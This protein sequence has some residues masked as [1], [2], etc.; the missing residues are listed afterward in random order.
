[1]QL[2]YAT[3]QRERDFRIAGAGEEVP[4]GARV[5]ATCT[6]EAAVEEL[7]ETTFQTLTDAE[8]YALKAQVRAARERAAR[9]AQD[10]PARG[11]FGALF[12]R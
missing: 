2:V 5:Y 1:M 12:G 10:G 9:E 4:A 3:E 7:G 11:L 6:A 8:Y